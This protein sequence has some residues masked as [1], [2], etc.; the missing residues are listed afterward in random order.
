VKG[1][2]LARYEVTNREFRRFRAGH[3]S[4]DYEGHSLNGDDQPVV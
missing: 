1:F 2:K 4:K 3:D